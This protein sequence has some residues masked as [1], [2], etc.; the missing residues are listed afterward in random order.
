[1]SI[2]CCSLYNAEDD[3]HAVCFFFLKY[4]FVCLLLTWKTTAIS[5]Q[6][7]W[8]VF[9]GDFYPE[10]LMQNSCYLFVFSIKHHRETLPSQSVNKL[11]S[12]NTHQDNM[13]AQTL[14]D[15]PTPKSFSA[16]W[17]QVLRLETHSQAKNRW[18]NKHQ[19]FIS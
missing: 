13:W 5:R 7:P 3:L 4:V 14:K 15:T 12:W 1:M 19:M 6:C 16:A 11:F 9:C 18:I 8:F 17:H 2:S 10:V